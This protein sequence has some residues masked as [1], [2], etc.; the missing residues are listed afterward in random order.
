MPRDRKTFRHGVHPE[1]R[2][3]MTE[4]RP[5]ERIPFPDEVVLPLS[6]HLGAP[7]KPVVKVG[8]K[9]YRGQIV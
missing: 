4:G 3:E 5:I 2:K 7:S 8:D 9:V 6:Q 1:E